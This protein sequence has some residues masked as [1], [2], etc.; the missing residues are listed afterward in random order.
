MTELS[1]DAAEALAAFEGQ[2]LWLDG[3]VVLSADAARSL[4][5]FQGA[6][7]HLDGLQ[8]LPADTA[9]GLAEFKGQAL[10][11]N[12]V[13]ALSPDAAQAIAAFQCDQLKLNRITTLSAD[14]ARALAGFAG[15]ELWLNGLATLEPEAVAA[16]TGFR[17]DNLYLGTF[18]QRLG[19]GIPLDPEAARLVCTCARGNSPV[20]LWQLTA[21]ENA[22]AVE[23]AEILATAR[24]GLA[25]PH[26]KRISPRT[27]AALVK[28]EDIEIP[29]I[30]TLE[31]IREPDGRPTED[32]VVPDGFLEF[33]KRQRR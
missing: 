32:V 33:Q 9:R 7:L 20:A 4:A 6:V 31:L 18:C 1:S 13:A 22:D 19:G 3:L 25:I 27:L 14:A 10:L 12:R 26:L 28:K 16:L 2:D 17:G 11:L 8:T 15:R 24:G 21:I 30:E 5:R 23:I 29:L